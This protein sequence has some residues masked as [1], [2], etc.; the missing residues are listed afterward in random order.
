MKKSRQVGH[1]T[2]SVLWLVSVF[3]LCP[4][5][6]DAQLP[7]DMS[8]ATSRSRDA[9]VT[10]LSATY[11]WAPE[12]NVASRVSGEIRS[13]R[14]FDL[15]YDQERSL[16]VTEQ[17][18][19]DITLEAYRRT[20]PAWSA[21][22]G[23]YTYL[24][25]TRERGSFQATVNNLTQ[26]QQFDNQFAAQLVGPAVTVSGTATIA[27]PVAID[28]TGALTLAPVFAYHFTQSISLNPLVADV[29]ELDYWD[30]GHTLIDLDA[31]VALGRWLS[32]N[33]S[34]QYQRLNFDKLVLARVASGQYDFESAKSD[35]SDFE[36]RIGGTVVLPITEDYAAELGGSVEISGIYDHRNNQW[37]QSDPVWYVTARARNRR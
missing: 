7:V 23:V 13:D 19:A 35:I 29:G 8:I 1:V 36:N 4:A 28:L 33:A 31:E 16:K 6:V 18:V 32:V 14:T 9:V 5:P 24:R 12:G 21:G 25:N 34:T 11:W 20:F 37:D 3:I 30:V 17:W 15:F 22:A 10:A 27:G 26:S 2:L